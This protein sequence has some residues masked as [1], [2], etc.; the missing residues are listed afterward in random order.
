MEKLIFTNAEFCRF[1]AEA[2]T[3]RERAETAERERDDLRDAV[4]EAT[5]LLD[6]EANL[7]PKEHQATLREVVRQLT[8][9]LFGHGGE[10]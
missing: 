1:V 5:T 7:G 9:A 10:S 4:Q 8:I 6:F 2:K 3:Q